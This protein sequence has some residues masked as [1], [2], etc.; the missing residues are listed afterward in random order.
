MI[1]LSKLFTAHPRA[2]GESYLEHMA[3]ALGFSGRLFRAAFAALIHGF[4]PGLCE[5]TASQTV[6]GMS[7]ELRAR[8]ARLATSSNH[9]ELPAKA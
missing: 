4:V 8:R 2:A 1:V 6:L 9:V 3:F 7:D 5:T